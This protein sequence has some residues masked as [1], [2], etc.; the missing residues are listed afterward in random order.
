MHLMKCQCLSLAQKI[1]LEAFTFT[2]KLM[3][4]IHLLCSLVVS[5]P[6]LVRGTSCFYWDILGALV[7][8]ALDLGRWLV[9]CAAGLVSGLIGDFTSHHWGE[10]GP[11]TACQ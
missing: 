9:W 6:E 8:P 4:F 10:S 2:L 5:L 7:T 11:G 3:C 1:S